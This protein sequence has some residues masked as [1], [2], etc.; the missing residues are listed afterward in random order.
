MKSL[1]L[2][3]MLVPLPSGIFNMSTISRAISAGDVNT[4]EKFFD[5]TV[6]IAILGDEDIFERAK[7]TDLLKTFFS[8]NQPKTFS[9]VH[10]GSSKGSDSIYCIGNLATNTGLFRVYIYLH[11]QDDNGKYLIQELRFDKEG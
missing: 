5:E 8:K 3:L 6:E 4:L 11:I 7:A 2:A 1:L 9:Q 10:Q